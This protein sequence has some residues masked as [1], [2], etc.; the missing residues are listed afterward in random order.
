MP[1]TRLLLRRSS[2]WQQR[3]YVEAE[4]GDVFSEL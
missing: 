2:G 4:N 3:L 1:V